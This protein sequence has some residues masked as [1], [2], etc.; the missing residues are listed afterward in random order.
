MAVQPENTCAK[1]FLRLRMLFVVANDDE[2]HASLLFYIVVLAV[3][4]NK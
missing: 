2:T 4:K 1:M 3:L